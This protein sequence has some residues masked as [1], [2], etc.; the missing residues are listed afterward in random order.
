[1][2]FATLPLTTQTPWSLFIP[3]TRNLKLNFFKEGNIT[4][5]TFPSEFH[6]TS[7]SNYTLLK[8]EVLAIWVAVSLIHKRNQI[9]RALQAKHKSY[10]IIPPKK[11]NKNI[12]LHM[13]SLAFIPKYLWEIVHSL[14]KCCSH[15]DGNLITYVSQQLFKRE[16]VEIIYPIEKAA[17]IWAG[18]MELPVLEF[19]KLNVAYSDRE[20]MH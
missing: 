11:R 20:R 9:I 14:W 4:G 15:R 19:G 16:E 3:E 7:K 13:Y 1:M 12:I 10:R 2:L 17:G 18:K 8:C 5:G 6:W